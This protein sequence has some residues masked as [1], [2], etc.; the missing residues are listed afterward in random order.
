[1][2]EELHGGEHGKAS[3][4]EFLKGTLLGLFRGKDW[5]S[6]LEISE[7]SVVVNGSDEEDHLC[8]SESR[9][10]IDGGNSVWNIGESESWG[11]VSWESEGLW[12]DV[13]E[14]AKLGN[15]SV[16]YFREEKRGEINCSSAVLIVAN[17]GKQVAYLEFSGAV[18]VE[19]LLVDVARESQRIEESGRVDDTE[20]VFVTHLGGDRG[21][22]GGGRGK[23]DSRAEEGE[24]ES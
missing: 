18:S 2:T 6:R 5:L 12:D 1:M 15:T 22:A 19:G 7:E 13:S 24:E 3:V 11:D 20:L 17:V 16:L 10:S 8:P 9:D 4:L 23:G 14:D 21:T